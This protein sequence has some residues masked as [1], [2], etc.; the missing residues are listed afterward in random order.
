MSS[1]ALPQ[2]SGNNGLSYGANVG[3][4]FR[5]LLAALLAVKPSEQAAPAAKLRD[6]LALFRMARD[7]EALSPNL[8]AELRF[9]AAR[10]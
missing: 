3:R 5:S 8:A 6:Q 4:A 1:I 7:Y 9:I 2:H 10:G